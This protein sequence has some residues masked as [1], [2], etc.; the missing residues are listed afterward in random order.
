MSS[1]LDW[2]DVFTTALA[3]GGIEENM[4]PSIYRIEMDAKAFFEFSGIVPGSLELQNIE[5]DEN[6][7]RYYWKSRSTK[8]ICPMCGEESTS[9]AHEYYTKPIQD[10]PRDNLTVRH[11]VTFQKY[12]CNNSE[13]WCKIFTERFI[14]FSEEGARKTVRFKKYCVERSLGCGCNPAQNELRKEGAIISNDSIARYLKVETAK[15]IE[16]NITADNVKV[17]CL[18]DINLRKGDK[19]S[20]CTV[21]LDGESHK[22]LIIIKGTTKEAAMRALKQFPSSEYLSRDRASAYSSAGDECGKTQVADNFHLIDNAQKAVEDAISEALPVKIY[23]REGDG[24]MSVTPDGEENKRASFYVPEH[25][26]ERR[27][28]LAELTSAKAQKYRNTIKMLELDSK[29]M[30]T[31]SIAQEMNLSIKDVRSLR[32][33][34]VNTFQKVD[35]KIAAKE[36]AKNVNGIKTVSGSGVRPSGESI[37]E[38]FRET[39]IELWNSGENHRSILPILQSQ[40]YTGSSNAIYQYIVKLRK[41]MPNTLRQLKDGKKN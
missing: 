15:K 10:I 29:G 31:A 3:K 38:P 28:E 8:A 21:F 23:I 37:V 17:I 35:E 2:K 5:R 13:C 9:I 41:E 24:W 20:G 34:A 33:T 19:S 22:V 7:I 27:I 12:N 39:V 32:A 1:I 36:L 14:E 16:E 11:I 4:I 25:I 30:R 6:E 18:D 40:G 26:V